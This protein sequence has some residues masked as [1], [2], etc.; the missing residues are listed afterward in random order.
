MNSRPSA[1]LF[2]LPKPVAILES[3]IRE[4]LASSLSHIAEQVEP[5][6]EIDT[7]LVDTVCA[8]IRSHRVDP[9]VFA[10]YQSVLDE[11]RQQRYSELP[12]IFARLNE[13]STEPATFRIQRFGVETLGDDAAF[14]SDIVFSEDFGKEPIRDPGLER[15][16]ATRKDLEEAFGLIGNVAPEAANEIQTLW[17]RIFVGEASSGG[18]SRSFAG[19]TSF[20]LWGS[21]FIN[22]AAHKTRIDCAEYLIHEST[23]ALLFAL[24]ASEPLVLNKLSERYPSPLRRDPRPMDGIYHATLVCGRLIVFHRKV[25]ASSLIRDTDHPII[26][27]KLRNLVQAFSDGVETVRE[28]G[29][30]SDPGASFLDQIDSKV[31]AGS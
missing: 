18:N 3:E 9:A 10:G 8:Q 7:A 23:H 28:F 4:Q 16:E 21:S 20:L 14:F 27:D 24:S 13:L 5:V 1:F 22:A 12:R 31:R 2:E 30:L 19:V 11:V 15:Y 17:S 29:N 6:Q 25:N 26:E